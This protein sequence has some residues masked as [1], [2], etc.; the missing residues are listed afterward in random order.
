MMGVDRTDYLM[1]GAK[2]DPDK[3]SARYDELEPEMCG[4]PGKR[5]DLIYDGMSGKYAYAGKVVV[6][7][8]PYDGI[9][10]HEVKMADMPDDP[11]ALAAA[12]KDATGEPVVE[13]DFKL[14]LFT[15]WH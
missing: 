4:E 5:F 6:K 8:D 11:A 10:Y 12:I 3:V 1:F 14:I 2:I 13:S 9:E 7:S 15:H